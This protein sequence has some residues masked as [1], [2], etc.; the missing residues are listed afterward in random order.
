MSIITALLNVPHFSLCHFDNWVEGRGPATLRSPLAEEWME[1]RLWPP[2]YSL[3]SLHPSLIP[4]C[5]LPSPALPLSSLADLGGLSTLLF[6]S[7]GDAGFRGQGAVTHS[8]GV[9]AGANLGPKDTWLGVGPL[10]HC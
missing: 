8:V 10:L 1:G 2:P 6:V 7:A 9:F 3:P 4:P 5:L